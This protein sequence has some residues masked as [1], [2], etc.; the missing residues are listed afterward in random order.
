LTVIIHTGSISID[1]LLGGGI[2]T[3]IV[4]DIYGQS[5]AGKSQLCF[6]L[7]ANYAKHSRQ[8]DRIL[9]IDTVGTFRPERISEIAGSRKSNTILNKIMFVRALNTYDQINAIGLIPDI[10]P[11]L[12]IID[13]ATSLFSY[14]FKG[15]TRH[16]V[17][18]NYIH[19][20][21]RAAINFDCAVVITNMV[22]DVPIRTTIMDQGGHNLTT[23]IKALTNSSQQREFMGASLSIYIHMK[24]KLEII[25]LEKSLFG[26]SLMQ[27]IRKDR[28]L[29]NITSKG[30]SD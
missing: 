29:F 27:P 18:M 11:R 9:F 14:E 28:V 20:L 4:T 6:T 17:L 12:V 21:S 8:E 2:R 24:L 16:L 10:N 25:N 5:G 23:A 3:G 19:R 22:R 7:C 15:A 13:T 30:I 26:A 1:R